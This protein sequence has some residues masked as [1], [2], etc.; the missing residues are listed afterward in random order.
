MQLMLL[1]LFIFKHFPT[2][3]RIVG[4]NLWLENGDV[5]TPYTFQ[6]AQEPLLWQQMLVKIQKLEKAF[7]TTAWPE[8]ASGLCGYCPVKTCP[9]NRS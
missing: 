8:I 2:V 4:V 5:G 7:A 3:N 1:A 9:N 6:R